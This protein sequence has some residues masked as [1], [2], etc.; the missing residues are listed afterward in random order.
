MGELFDS[1]LLEEQQDICSSMLKE[2]IDYYNDNNTDCYLSLLDDSKAF[3]CVEYMYMKLFN[4][5]RDQ[6]MCLLMPRL[7]MNMNINQLIQVKWNSAMSM[8]SY[9]SYV[10]FAKIFRL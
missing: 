7:L 2:T 10:N 8:K 1:I 4:T 9:N 3:D 6:I 5:L